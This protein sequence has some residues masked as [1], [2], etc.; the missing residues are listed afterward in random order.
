MKEYRIYRTNETRTLTS[1]IAHPTA[2]YNFFVTV[3]DLSVLISTFALA[4]VDKN[5]NESLNS[6]L[7]SGDDN[8]DKVSPAVLKN[9]TVITQ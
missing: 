7:T 4:A 9:L 6:T 2:S 5:N 8:L 1:T 3:P